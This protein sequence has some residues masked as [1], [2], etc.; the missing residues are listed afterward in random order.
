MADARVTE[1]DPIAMLRPRRKIAGYSAILLPFTAAGAVDWEGFTAHT[2]RT[3]AAGLTP[4][5]NMDTGYVQLLDDVTRRAVLAQ[6]REALGGGPFVAGACVVDRPGD[7]FAA[8]EY[9]R[10]M[11]LIR[12]FGGTPVIFQSY[13]LTQSD[14]P[15]IIAAYRELARNGP[16]IGFELGKMFAPCG[17]IYD[18]E[19]YA[20][21]L[22]IPECL[23]AKHSSL[24]RTLEWERLLLRDRF[25]PE[26]KVFTGNDLAI[27]MVMYGSD[28]LLGLSTFAPD[29]FAR[30]DACWEQG[31]PAFYELNDLLQYLGCLAFRSP[32]PAYKHNAAQFLKLRG[33]IGCDATHPQSARRPESDIEILREI[34]AQ[35]VSRS[36]P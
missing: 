28:Y 36:A 17:A 16:F 6:T 2:L 14:R 20:D 27:D 15:G 25:R 11:D 7:R 10:Q 4:A 23:G 33:W 19:T 8:A 9:R 12:E 34:A 3:A 31:D 21:L 32:V 24:S 18:L 29:L 1:I 35:V 26:F 13:G 30:R 5:V 22:Q